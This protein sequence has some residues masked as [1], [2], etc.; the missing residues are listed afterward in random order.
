MNQPARYSNPIVSSD[1]PDPDAIA[2]TGGGY[3]LVASSFDR[4]PGLPLWRSDDLVRWHPAG[5]AGGHMP[6]VQPSGGVWAPAIREHDG[7][8][9]ITWADPDRGVFVVDAPQ[10]EGPWSAP[11]LVLP[12]PGPIDPCPFW[13][14]DGRAWLIH[15][16]ARSRA[17]FANRLDIVEV[18]PTLTRAVGPARTAI[19]GDAIEGCS[20]LEGP[21]LYRRGD[22]YLVFAPAGGVE[23]GWQYVFRS[24]DLAGPWEARIVLEQGSTAVNGPHQ[25]AWVVGAGGEEWFLHFQHTPQH[26]RIL[27]LQPLAWGDDGWP[28]VGAAVAGGPPEPVAEWPWPTPRPAAAPV[29]AASA[30]DGWH[31]RGSAPRDVIVAA[32]ERCIRLRA[33]GVLARPLDRSRGAQVTLLEGSGSLAVVGEE[34]HRVRV[35][36]GE[37]REPITAEDGHEVLVRAAAPVRLGFETDGAAARFHVDGQP[38]GGWFTPSPTRWTGVEYAIA[39]HDAD[40]LFEVAP[41]DPR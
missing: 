3:A 24:R 8:L 18:D 29:A 14:D 12:G 27:H 15:G 21:K 11:R 37:G 5:F 26:G 22:D 19:D 38:V 6:L 31:G 39:A 32:D 4:Q 1:V 10:L 9:F 36:P 23:T 35:V 34:Q 41:A 25:G 30:A 7:R 28:R 16:W 40:A 13:D 20:V 17:G 33:D 2:L